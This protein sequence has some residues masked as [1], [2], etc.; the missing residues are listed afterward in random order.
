MQHATSEHGGKQN[1][2]IH[3][4]TTTNPAFPPPKKKH[5]SVR[6]LYYALVAATVALTYYYGFLQGNWALL[7]VFAL[8]SWLLGAAGHGVFPASPASSCV[9]HECMNVRV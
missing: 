5:H 9:M 3:H 4:L 6:R 2:Y 1:S 8:S 7:Y